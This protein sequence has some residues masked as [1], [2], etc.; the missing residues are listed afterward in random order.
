MAE[1]FL[2][3]NKCYNFIM[4][5]NIL[6]AGKDYPDSEDFVE[7][8]ALGEFNVSCA[9][10]TAEDSVKPS[11]GITICDWNRDS[12]ISARSLIIQAETANGFTDNYILYFD[13][14]YFTAKY[15]SCSTDICAR[16][17]DSMI[18]GFQYL[19]LAILNRI[20]QHKTPAKI[21][22]IL[23]TNPTM[24]DVIHSS[25]LKK[26]N[27]TPSNPIVS[28]AEAAFA[29][30]AENLAAQEMNND[31][32]SILLIT[33]DQQNETM[34]SDSNL[35]SWLKEYISACDQLK[36]GIQKSTNWIKAG[37]KAS[38]GFSLFK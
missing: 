5:K 32:V 14:E 33:G 1:L 18:L 11:S 29:T 20:E 7:K 15:S 26:M 17:C 23:K 3:P 24:N 2:F 30:F 36:K 34:S 13:A 35:G 6:I 10:N 21:L 4:S 9:G 31:N 8:I 12:A 28:A 38:G 19:S 27:I 25:A 22:F 16:A 37:A